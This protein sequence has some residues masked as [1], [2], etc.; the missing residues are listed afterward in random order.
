MAKRAQQPEL[1]R[2]E[3]GDT[4]MDGKRVAREVRP[5]TKGT[6]KGDP[7]N[8]GPVP[9]ENRPGHR[10]EKDQDKPEL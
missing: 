8:A 9:P 4:D 10:P 6:L 5:G 3:R 2:S 7:E 1:A